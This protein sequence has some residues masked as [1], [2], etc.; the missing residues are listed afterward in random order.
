[1]FIRQTRRLSDIGLRNYWKNARFMASCCRSQFLRPFSVVN[2]APKEPTVPTVMIS[3]KT[4]SKSH[5]KDANLYL[6]LKSLSSR[7]ESKLLKNHGN[8]I[9]IKNAEDKEIQKADFEIF[10]DKDTLINGSVFVS[11]NNFNFR[12]RTKLSSI[13]SLI[14]QVIQCS[15]IYK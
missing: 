14:Y 10:F 12:Y 8:S 5:S 3:Y 4:S 6:I 11:N 2:G 1:M 13:E 7:L 9:S 15:D